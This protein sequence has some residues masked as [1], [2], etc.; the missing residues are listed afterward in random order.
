MK[1][2]LECLYVMPKDFPNRLAK[3]IWQAR[4]EQWDIEDDVEVL[5]KEEKK[6]PGRYGF[7]AIGKSPIICGEYTE[8][9]RFINWSDE[10]YG[11]YLKDRK[12]W[13]CYRHSYSKS[14]RMECGA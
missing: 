11:V 6:F 12:I 10:S 8:D 4:E 1:P 3:W 2:C 9:A 7:C 14:K 13:V 5:W